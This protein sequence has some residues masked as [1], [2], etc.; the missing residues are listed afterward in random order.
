MKSFTYKYTLA[1]KISKLCLNISK[2]SQLIKN[3]IV[4]FFGGFK[5]VNAT[6]L[7]AVYFTIANYSKSSIN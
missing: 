1:L 3:K 6:V 2:S 5:T 4:K 7:C